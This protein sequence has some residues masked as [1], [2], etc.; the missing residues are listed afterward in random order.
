M[1]PGPALCSGGQ[2]H[3]RPARGQEGPSG[4][5]RDRDPP[6]PGRPP[7]PGV[8]HLLHRAVALNGIRQL[9]SE[10][11]QLETLLLQR[12]SVA[13]T[14]SRGPVLPRGLLQPLSSSR[15]SAPRPSGRG[16]H[17]AP[18]PHPAPHCHHAS[19][20]GTGLG[21]IHFAPCRLVPPQTPARAPRARPASPQTPPPAIPRTTPSAPAA[22]PGAGPTPYACLVR[23]TSRYLRARE[24]SVRVPQGRAT[25]ARGARPQSQATDPEPCTQPHA[26][27][28]LTPPVSDRPPHH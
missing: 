15:S 27:L 23:T 14:G 22:E 25:V 6:P 20:L 9:S 19:A 2:N 3:T 28:Q 5:P 24:T 4:C 16:P 18:S 10:A 26:R 13:S 12:G 8:P 7:P 1:A 11:V 21:P 17:R